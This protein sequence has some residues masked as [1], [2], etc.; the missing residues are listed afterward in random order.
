MD[1]YRD[2]S[3]TIDSRVQDLLARMNLEEKLAQIVNV[4]AP[5]FTRQSGLVLQTIFYPFELYS[6]TCGKYSLDLWYDGDTFTGEEYTGV[7]TLD[8]S[9]TLD[10]AR[11]QMV[12]YVVN[13]SQTE[14]VET[15][16]QLT[17]GDFKD[18]HE[19]YTINGQDIK[20]ENTFE[21]P[22]E[23]TTRESTLIARGRSLNYTFEPHSV[24]AIIGDIY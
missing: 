2:S 8:V 15:V 4:I 19:V 20:A 1:A 23:V 17:A 5:I 24:T 21:S 12:L 16:I 10:D 9:A 13:R 3:K 18:A 11:K 14:E 22:H 6:R 7:R